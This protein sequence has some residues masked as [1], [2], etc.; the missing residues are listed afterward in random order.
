MQQL[1]KY[2]VPSIQHISLVVSALAGGERVSTLAGGERKDLT[3][4]ESNNY[5]LMWLIVRQ[6]L[7]RCE[8]R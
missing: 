5:C 2:I 3:S 4:Q 6:R 8:H 1:R 7:P